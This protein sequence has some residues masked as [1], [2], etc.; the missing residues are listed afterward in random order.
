MKAGVRIAPRGVV[1][2]PAR[3]RPSRAAMLNVTP[4]A[5][6]LP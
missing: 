1:S 6:C 2:R 3:A 4:E 5:M